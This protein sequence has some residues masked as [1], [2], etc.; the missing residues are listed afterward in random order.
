MKDFL[1]EKFGSNTW[2]HIICG[3]TLYTAKYGKILALT[4]VA[5]LVGALPCRLK[6]HGSDSMDSTCPG[7]GFVLQLGHV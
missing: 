1:P 7:C 2:V 6:G 5:Q 3:S 4:G